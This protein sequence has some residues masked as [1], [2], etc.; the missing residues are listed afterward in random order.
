MEGVSELQEVI[1]TVK[2]QITVHRK[3]WNSCVHKYFIHQTAKI[4]ISI[5]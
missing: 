5:I 3:E 2:V 4:L 1:M